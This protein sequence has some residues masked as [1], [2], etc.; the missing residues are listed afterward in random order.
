[1]KNQGAFVPWEQSF[2]KYERNIQIG[3]ID[4]DESIA[5]EFL[6]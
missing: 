2:L 1:M 3:T 6:F 4:L 5:Q